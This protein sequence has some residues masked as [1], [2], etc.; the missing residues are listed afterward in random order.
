MD[1]MFLGGGSQRIEVN[2]SATEV[3]IKGD[4]PP[5]LYLHP[6]HGVASSSALLDQLARHYRV[7]APSHPGFGGSARPAHIE[8]VDALSYFYLDLIESMDLEGITL[9]GS[10]FGGWIASEIAVKAGHR[11]KRL[12][13]VGTL[14]TKF[15]DREHSQFA[16]PFMI[17]DQ[18]L[19][20][21]YFNDPAIGAAA[22][23]GFD[24]KAMGSNAA[25]RFA[26]NAEGLMR[27]GWA[28]LLHD[29]ALRHKL[30]RLTLP[31]LLLWGAQDRIAPVDC[32]RAFAAAANGAA[33]ELIEGAGHYTDVEKPAI[34]ADKI[35]AFA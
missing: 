19:P 4:G 1:P 25:D 32:G 27:F 15:N 26:A 5:L 31:T 9:V 21:L 2:G 20:A 17:P 16:D 22:F 7:I 3:I 12:I 18:D 30:H 35:H 11:L 24:F 10:S 23:G 33:F 13:L 6:G 34:V 28:P 14:G 29:P 8:T